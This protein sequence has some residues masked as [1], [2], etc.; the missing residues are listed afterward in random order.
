MDKLRVGVIGAGRIS[1][2]S[3]LPCLTA[4]DDVE[5]IL[6]EVDEGRL[7]MVAD[8]F[9]I[10]ET[11]SD[12]RAMLAGDDLDAVFVLTPPDGHVRRQQ[13]LPGGGRADA[14]GEAARHEHG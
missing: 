12:Y 8:R 6:C 7:R 10:K 14:D 5:V 3:H 9:G 2:G 13:G 4:F 11:H 1:A